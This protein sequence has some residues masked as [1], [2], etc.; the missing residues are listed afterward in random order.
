LTIDDNDK[1][2]DALHDLEKRG[3]LKWLK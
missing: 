1:L 3:I 2:I